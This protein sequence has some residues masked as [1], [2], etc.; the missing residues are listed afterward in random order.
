MDAKIA[1]ALFGFGVGAAGYVIVK[2]W[3]LPIRDYKRLKSAIEKDVALYTNSI[4]QGNW[5]SG[6][7]KRFKN[8]KKAVSDLNDT[9]D[10]DLPVW[11]KI[12]LRRRGES[13]K[14][15]EKHLMGLADTK[16][17]SHAEKR[18]E[19]AKAALSMQ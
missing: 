11:Y 7:K 4:A 18:L 2:Y 13:P 1:G 14:E 3:I 8:T 16:D 6:D 9:Y 19:K 15:A 17:A 12:I 10:F 5:N